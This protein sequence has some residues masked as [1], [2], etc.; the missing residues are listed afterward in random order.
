MSEGKIQRK[1]TIIKGGITAAP[2]ALVEVCNGVNTGKLL[3]DVKADERV[4]SKL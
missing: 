3:M 2:E 1:E 4:R